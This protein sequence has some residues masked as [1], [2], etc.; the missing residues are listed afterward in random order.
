MKY[1]NTDNQLSQKQLE[2]LFHEYKN[3]V[4][5]FALK[6]LKSETLANDVVQEVFLALCRKNISEVRNIRSFIFQISHNKIVDLI[7]EHAKDQSLREK[8]WKRISKEQTTAD[9]PIIE[10]EYFEQLHKAKT[11]LT[12]RQL[13]IFELSR[14]EGLTQKEIAK[15]LN[16]SINTVKNHMVSGIKTLKEYLQV[17]SDI[18]LTIL[19]LLQLA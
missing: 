15:K 19:L 14:E 9:Q 18:I 12:P 5:G 6:N 1:K 11:L 2:K 4:Y 8:M 7:R 3:Q 10:I 16:L 17:N 13:L